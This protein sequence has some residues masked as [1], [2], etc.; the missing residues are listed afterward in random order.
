MNKMFL[1]QLP[2]NRKYQKEIGLAKGI[3]VFFMVCS[4]VLGFLSNTETQNQIFSLIIMI[5]ATFPAAPVFLFAMGMGSVY[6]R[7]QSAGHAA[8]RGLLLL[9]GG[10]GLN[11]IR[12]YLPVL[13]GVKTGLLSIEVFH[14]NTPLLFL[15]E[16]DI[17]H[18]AGVSFL[19]IALF[20]SLK[21]PLYLYPLAGLLLQGLNMLLNPGTT[22]SMGGDAFAGLIWASGITSYFPL[23]NWSIYPLA[24]VAFGKILIHCTDKGW[25][26][27]R[28]ML[29]GFSLFIAGAALLTVI[30]WE[31]NID[32]Q[33]SDYIYYHHKV[34]GNLIVGG[35]MLIWLSTVSLAGRFFP[36]LVKNRLD[37]WG[38]KVTIIFVAHWILLGWSLLLLRPYS[39]GTAASFVVM[40]IL[41][42]A[43]DRVAFL[44]NY[45]KH[46]RK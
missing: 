33:W 8:L 35:L 39:L 37:F 34:I 20:R 25:L 36:E 21:M 9:A 19:L 23:L 32:F 13:L 10:Y 14:Y 1:D 29:L 4:H 7:S 11:A 17:L 43:S 41:L 28:T 30:N 26:Y 6:S 44:W 27:R 2:V 15:L 5:L 31:K 24:G 18:L 22:G 46:E 12:F 3:A 42:L 40:A 16:T 45:R 38:R